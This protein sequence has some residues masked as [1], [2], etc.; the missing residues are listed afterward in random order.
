MLASQMISCT[1]WLYISR[2]V[3]ALHVQADLLHALEAITAQADVL[4]DLHE[5][6]L[7]GLVPALALAI[8]GDHE[9]GDSRFLCLK[10]LC[11]IT[12]PF[13]VPDG[14]DGSE[15]QPGGNL[16]CDMLGCDACEQ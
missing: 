2:H 13:L 3:F 12:L 4:M 11:D 7:E 9:T 16:C 15:D 5:P 8:R 1:A 6:V 10:L 14:Q